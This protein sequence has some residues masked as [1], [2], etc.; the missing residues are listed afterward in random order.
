MEN[1]V[2]KH[3][4]IVRYIVEKDGLFVSAARFTPSSKLET[5]SF[6]SIEG[7]SLKYENTEK[8]IEYAKTLAKEI[9]GKVI[10]KTTTTIITINKEEVNINE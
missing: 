5:V 9:K 1:K 8:N 6:T 4:V 7:N 3:E 10:K 2:A